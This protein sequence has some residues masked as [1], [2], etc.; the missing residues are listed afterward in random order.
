MNKLIPLKKR[1]EIDP[2]KKSNNI[3]FILLN[4]ILNGL[5]LKILKC[6]YLTAYSQ[7]GGKLAVFFQFPIVND[8]KQ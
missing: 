3:F 6:S 7:N 2:I 1:F 5:Y 8:V 4:R